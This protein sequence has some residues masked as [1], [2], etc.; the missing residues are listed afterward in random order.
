[1]FIDI[2]TDTRAHTRAHTHAHAHTHTHAHAHVHA[3]IVSYSYTVVQNWMRSGP[4]KQLTQRSDGRL[5]KRATNKKCRYVRQPRMWWQQILGSQSARVA[6]SNKPNK[7][8]TFFA[9]EA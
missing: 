7:T 5:A 1:M 6:S 4:L 2:L 8:S 3:R 9:T